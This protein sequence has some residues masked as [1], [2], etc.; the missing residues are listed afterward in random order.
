MMKISG[1]ILTIIF[2]VTC[3]GNLQS[4]NTPRVFVFTDI[5]IDSGDPDDRQS[6]IHLIWYANE[7]RIEGVVPERWNG[8]I[9]VLAKPGKTMWLFATM[10]KAHWKLKDRKCI[11]HFSKS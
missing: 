4:Q 1:F 11:T 2:L 3:F 7:I 8:I 6:L 9:P 10:P 5:N